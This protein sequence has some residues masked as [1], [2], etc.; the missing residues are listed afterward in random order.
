MAGQ[1]PLTSPK[2]QAAG[3]TP[4]LSHPPGTLNLPVELGLAGAVLGAGQPDVT[5]RSRHAH[6]ATRQGRPRMEIQATGQSRHDG[7]EP[8]PIGA[9]A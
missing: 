6:T 1:L 7:T 2:S 4:N 3:G 9:R 8:H 5:T